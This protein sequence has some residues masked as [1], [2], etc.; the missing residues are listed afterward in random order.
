MGDFVFCAEAAV[1]PRTRARAD[2]AAPH[3]PAGLWVPGRA[4]SGGAARLRRWL[5]RPTAWLRRSADNAPNLLEI[6]ASVGRTID[7]ACPCAW[8][9]GP[10]RTT[11][12]DHPRPVP[13]GGRRRPGGLGPLRDGVKRDSTERRSTEYE[14]SR[15]SRRCNCCRVGHY[16]PFGMGTAMALDRLVETIVAGTVGC[17][18]SPELGEVLDRPTTHSD[19]PRARIDS[20]RDP[21]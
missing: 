12:A 6:R 17:V 18:M 14:L 19:A 3:G 16:D 9:P 11:P 21:H 20:C 5:P 7:D 8:W 10:C 2:R 4:R 13:A 15:L 1:S